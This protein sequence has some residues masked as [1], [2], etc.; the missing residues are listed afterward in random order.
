LAEF[1]PDNG[2]VKNPAFAIEVTFTQI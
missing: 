2:R 1:F